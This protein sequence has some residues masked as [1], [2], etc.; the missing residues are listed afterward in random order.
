M[1]DIEGLYF[2]GPGWWAMLDRELKD[3]YDVDKVLN[4]VCVKE[5]FGQARV[6]YDN[7]SPVRAGFVQMYEEIVQNKSTETC[8][9]C[10]KRGTLR[11]DRNRMQCRCERCDKASKEE[12]NEIMRETVD[13]YKKALAQIVSYLPKGIELTEREAAAIRYGVQCRGE[14]DSI[15]NRIIRRHGS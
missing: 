10:G 4:G 5:K 7:F 1:P 9:L 6:E 3:M 13:R 8:E 15:M 11:T 14:L 12:R 2:T